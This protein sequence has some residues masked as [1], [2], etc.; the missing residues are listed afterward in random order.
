MVATAAVATGCGGADA[1]A[2]SAPTPVPAP[3]PQPL[4]WQQELRV[5]DALQHLVRQCMNRH[6]FEYWED[7]V[8]TLRESR[9]V[10]YVRDDVEWARTYGY[11]SRIDA[12]YERYRARNP[13]GAYRESLPEARRTAFDTALDGGDQA[14]ILTTRLPAGGEIRK[15]LGGCTEEAE[16]K[17]YGDPDEWFRTRKVAEG[18]PSLYGEELMKDRQLTAAL[19]AW[20]RCMRGAGHPY[21]DPPA[22]RDGALALSFA[23]EREIAVADASCARSMSLRQATAARERSFQDRLRPRYGSEV[24]AQRRLA[25]RAYDRAVRIVPER[26]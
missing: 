23:A 26:S 19:G 5:G 12:K 9:P 25:Q 22:A 14:R 11:G 21:A 10:G 4:T 8:L 18:L 24:D 13:N 7:R 16:R 17:L 6:G 2:R 20:S 3:P 1:V 15:R